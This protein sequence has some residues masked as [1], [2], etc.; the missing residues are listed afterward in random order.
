MSNLE[1]E[2]MPPE[3]IEQRLNHIDGLARL[4]DSQFTLPGTQ[5][6][7]G[8]DALVGL[9]PVI[10]DTIS[11]G[12]SGYIVA[13]AHSLGAPKR[14]LTRMG[15]NI[16]LDWL[17]GLVPLIGDIFDVGWK[18]NNRNA[19]LLRRHFT[20]KVPQKKPLR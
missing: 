11:L 16:F 6:K 7:L 18:A 17:I 12:V 1:A 19:D 20:P 15:F 14:L 8:L 5:I 13:H 2:I 4:M 10:G 3:H 9:V